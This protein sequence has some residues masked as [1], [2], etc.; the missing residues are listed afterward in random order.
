MQTVV[1]DYITF[2]YHSIL[3]RI[4]ASERKTLCDYLSTLAASSPS[5]GLGERGDKLA[6]SV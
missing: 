3:A 1:P 6:I 4:T 5:H 2:S